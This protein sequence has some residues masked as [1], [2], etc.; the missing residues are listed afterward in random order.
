MSLKKWHMLLVFFLSNLQLAK[1]TS[2]K[3]IN[4]KLSPLG[5]H[6]PMSIIPYKYLRNFFMSLKWDSLGQDW[7]LAHKH[8]LYIISGLLTVKY[9]KKP[10]MPLY[11]V[12]SMN[13]LFSFLSSLMDELIGVFIVLTSSMLNL[14]RRS[15]IYFS[16]LMKVPPFSFLT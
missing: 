16:W 9:S 3:P 13:L 10:I 1:S 4:S 8:T 6:K 15:L 11:I 2:E 14:W 7:N 12:E 5:Y